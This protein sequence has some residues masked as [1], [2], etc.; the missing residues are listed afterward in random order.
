LDTACLLLGKCSAR[1]LGVMAW[2]A[3]KLKMALRVGSA[4]A[5]NIS[6]LISAIILSATDWLQIYMQLFGCANLKS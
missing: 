1:A 6:R 5:W 2:R 4:M 3:S